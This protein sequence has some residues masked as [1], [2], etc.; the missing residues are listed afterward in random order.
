MIFQKKRQ[1][2]TIWRAPSGGVICLALSL[3]ICMSKPVVSHAIVV[4]DDTDAEFKTRCDLALEIVV[5]STIMWQKM[6]HYG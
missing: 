1:H 3:I 6:P 2:G 4:C 5:L